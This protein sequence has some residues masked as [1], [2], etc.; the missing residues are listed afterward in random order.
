VRITRL[1]LQDF[2]RHRDL[3]IELAHG[4]TII[5]GPN[6]AG[7]S[8]IQ[9]GLELALFRKATASTAE[10]E[11]LRSWGAAEDRRSITTLEFVVDDEA[12]QN[13]D[14]VVKGVL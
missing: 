5:R 9:R 11:A 7:K 6:E 13:G 12:G 14:N 10:L 8:T 4:F 2:G 3:D 1:R